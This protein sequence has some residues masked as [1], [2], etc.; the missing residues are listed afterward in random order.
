MAAKPYVSIVTSILLSPIN[1]NKQIKG[2]KK[3][4]PPLPW[5]TAQQMEEMRREELRIANDPKEEEEDPVLQTLRQKDLRM[6]RAISTLFYDPDTETT[7]ETYEAKRVRTDPETRVSLSSDS[8]EFITP[9][10]TMQPTDSPEYEE[11]SIVSGRYR[12]EDDSD[13]DASEYELIISESIKAKSISHET[14]QPQTS[15]SFEDREDLSTDVTRTRDETKTAEDTTNPTAHEST[16][17]RTHST[18]LESSQSHKDSSLTEEELAEINRQR[19]KLHFESMCRVVGMSKQEGDKILKE[20]EEQESIVKPHGI[21]KTPTERFETKPDP[22]QPD[23]PAVSAE[24]VVS[25]QIPDPKERSTAATAVETQSTSATVEPTTPI[26]PIPPLPSALMSTPILPSPLT[27]KAVLPQDLSII[28]REPVQHPTPPLVTHTPPVS[29]V[30]Y[31]QPGN[32]SS[33]LSHLITNPSPVPAIP[34]SSQLNPIISQLP[35]ALPTDTTK[36]NPLAFLHSLKPQTSSSLFK[37]P[38]VT[39][40]PPTSLSLFQTFVTSSGPLVSTAVPLFQTP[41][42]T[43]SAASSQLKQN[44]PF[45]N[46]EISYPIL[47]AVTSKSLFNIPALTQ[48]STVPSLILSTPSAAVP[49]ASPFKPMDSP[50]QI[51]AKPLLSSLMPQGPLLSSTPVLSR[52]TAELQVTPT[53]VPNLF[54]FNSQSTP[55]ILP[56]VSPSSQ[57]FTPNM[58][59]NFN[60]GQFPEANNSGIFLGPAAARSSAILPSNYRPFRSQFKKKR[61]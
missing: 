12:L 3:A 11:N 27:S 34:A 9:T 35:S 36:P 13:I 20:W 55:A 28:P 49:A 56:P 2:F 29:A 61:K 31:T 25:F 6:K 15:Q 30:T 52:P 54:S 42:A 51:Q 50:F 10:G 19:F 1:N 22:T 8:D 41:F 58:P 4:Q 59:V 53:P 37:L 43:L 46:L 5:Y 24:R 14:G 16:L 23:S 21:L 26:L 38:S 40:T 47:T 44:K 33:L 60:F 39:N 57:I 45:H 48:T 17:D 7:I 18:L 32:H